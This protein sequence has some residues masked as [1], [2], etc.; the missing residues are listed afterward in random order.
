MGARVFISCGQ[1]CGEREVARSVAGWF[2][3]QGFRP[4]VALEAQSIQD[5]NTGIIAELRRSDYYVFIDFRRERL[6]AHDKSGYCRGSL[7]S[8]QEL[9]IAHALGFE[10]AIFF[11]ETG[12]CLEGLCAFMAANATPFEDRSALPGLVAE[13]VRRRGWSP[14][15]SR[16]LVP[17]PLHWSQPIQSGD[18]RGRF[19]F[20]DIQNRRGDIGAVGAVARL[21]A[22]QLEGQAREP[23]PNRSPLKVTGQA[24]AFEQ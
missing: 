22:M 24:R 1:Q 3:E 19:L 9:A 11:R 8:H 4:Y 13:A 15:Y 18:L 23:S 10:H 12:V 7:F 14:K 20:V 6:D 2:T 5:I 17:G 21:A 16:N